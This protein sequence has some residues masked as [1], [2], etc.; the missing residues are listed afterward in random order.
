MAMLNYKFSKTENIRFMYRTSTNAPNIS[1]LQNIV[2]N[3]NPLLLRTGNPDLR[4]DYNHNISLR[5]G[6]TTTSKGNGLF[7]FAMG[8]FVNNY[9]GNRTI[10]ATND[11]VV[12]LTGSD[13]AGIQLN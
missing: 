13:S 7:I 11:T 5:Y 6:K 4:Q 12:H 10:I 3:S 9:I 1:Q 2:D 8:G